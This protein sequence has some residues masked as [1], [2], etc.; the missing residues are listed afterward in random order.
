MF[1]FI[2]KFPTCLALLILLLNFL[3]THLHV[4]FSFQFP[5]SSN[6]Q[7]FFSL[8][9]R[10]CSHLCTG[11]RIYCYKSFSFLLFVP[12]FSNLHP[13]S[14]LRVMICQLLLYSKKVQ[15]FILLLHYLHFVFIWFVFSLILCSGFEIGGV[16]YFNLY[17]VFP[18][19]AQSF[20]DL[21]VIVIFI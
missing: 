14:F 15:F 3:T 17:S 2:P 11:L 18:S 13:P 12:L 21:V 9:Q 6:L 7:H 8:F 1:N 5:N 16:F 10:N 19:I 20:S 4:S